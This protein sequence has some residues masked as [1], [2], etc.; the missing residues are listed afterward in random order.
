MDEEVRAWTLHRLIS[1]AAAVAPK[2]GSVGEQGAE[3]TFAQL[4]EAAREIWS[5]TFDGEI[6]ESSAVLLAVAGTVFAADGQDGAQQLAEKL[7]SIVASIDG[8]SGD[9]AEET[10]E[11][12]GEERRAI[13]LRLFEERLCS[14]A[15]RRQQTNGTASEH[16]ER[17]TRAVASM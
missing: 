13:V 15:V 10:Q 9:D 12:V 11:T 4:I 6:D 1:T 7:G 2:S 3:V 16:I 14:A 5:R 8:S 17:Y